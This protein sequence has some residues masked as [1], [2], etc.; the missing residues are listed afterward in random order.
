MNNSSLWRSIALILSLVFFASAG[1]FAQDHTRNWESGYVV[2][3]TEIHIKDGMLNAY[4][5]D[6][7]ARWRKILE[8]QMEDGDVISYG[9]YLVADPR[10]GEPDLILTVTHKNWGT[11]DRD[12]D[13]FEKLG[14]KIF[15][16]DDNMR[17]ASIKRGELRSFG[18]SYTL[19]E[20]K[21][22]EKE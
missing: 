11:Y 12:D 18:S 14:E 9:M 7:N 4:V 8:A 10:E 16:S 22:K 5:N 17:E 15:G 3:V 19:Q 2:S 13:Y 21:F 20:I 6:L 1:A